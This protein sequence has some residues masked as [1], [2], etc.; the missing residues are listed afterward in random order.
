[1]FLSLFGGKL[2][3]EKP[4]EQFLKSDIDLHYCI[5]WANEHWTNQWV[6]SDFSVLVEQK[7]GGKKEWK[8]HFD[9]LLQFFKDPRY[10]KIGN[11]PV[12]TIY[13]PEIIDCRK[14][15]IEYWNELAKENG[16][17]GLCMVFQSAN[18]LVRQPNFDLSMFDYCGSY[19]PG[20]TFCKLRLK[21]ENFRCVRSFISSI[22]TF[23]EKHFCFDRGTIRNIYKKLFVSHS[24][25]N[26]LYDDVWKRILQDPDIFK[27][28]IPCA[29]TNWD[30]TSRHGIRG[31]VITGATPDKFEN[32]LKQ[33]ILKAKQKYETDLM[34]IFAWNEW[35][36]GG[37]LD[38]KISK[39]D[40]TR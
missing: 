12:M 36:E 20:L 26:F 22:L 5:S 13:R 21:N 37:Y 38:P 23:F 39:S 24:A 33:L 30:N 35:A 9:Y 11:R 1:M 2:L 3:L 34:F 15:M 28:I 40:L 31:S 14:E 18:Y 10:I 6:K 8:E 19:E 27:K 17:D 32:Y 29:F 25:E 4:V 16:F 7:Y